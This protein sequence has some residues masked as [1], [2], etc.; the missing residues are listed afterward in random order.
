LLLACFKAFES[1]WHYNKNVVALGF[2]MPISFSLFI[3][4]YANVGRK[5]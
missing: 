5:L 4:Q 3:I 2:G 1:Q